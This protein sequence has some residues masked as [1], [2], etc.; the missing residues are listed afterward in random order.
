MIV[1]PA[2]T[3]RATWTTHPTPGWHF[4]LQESGYTDTEISFEWLMRVFH[5]QTVT[6][7]NGEA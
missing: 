7:A 1:W 5:P 3:H 4:A 6:R 2:S